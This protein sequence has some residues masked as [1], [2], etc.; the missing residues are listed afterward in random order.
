MATLTDAHQGVVILKEG[1]QEALDTDYADDFAPFGGADCIL[2]E[3]EPTEAERDGKPYILLS[4][5]PSDYSDDWGAQEVRVQALCKANEFNGGR[6]GAVN[7][8][9]SQTLLS[10]RLTAFLRS[11]YETFNALG[12][13]GL[14]IDEPRR[15]IETRDGGVMQ[16]VTHRITFR[17]DSTY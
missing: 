15:S 5:E 7:E 13:Q 14:E 1:I 8:I 10:R 3:E 6:V 16:V 12:V 2:L 9:G 4:S 11:N 17:Y